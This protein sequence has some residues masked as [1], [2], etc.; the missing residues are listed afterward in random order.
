MYVVGGDSERAAAERLAEK[1]N[2]LFAVVHPPERGPYSNREVERYLA[3]TSEDGAPTVSANYLSFLRR[4]QKTNPTSNSLRAIARFFDIDPGYLL[5]DDEDA[6]RID[7]Q[8][9]ALAL[10]A[11]ANVR[12]IA[13]RASGLAPEAQ[14][15][16]LQMLD[17]LPQAQRVEPE[18]KSDRTEQDRDPAEGGAADE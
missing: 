5:A 11:N 3:E 13:T 15:W 9:E 17:T 4:A 14:S 18:S 6:R 1:L 7:Q 16:V 10:V 8:L 2:R 12:G